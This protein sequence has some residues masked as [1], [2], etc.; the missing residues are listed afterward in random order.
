MAHRIRMPDDNVVKKVQ[1]LKVAGI[2]RRGSSRL[3]WVDSM[4]SVFGII[5]EKTWRTKVN[6]SRSQNTQT[7][8][9]RCLL[10]IIKL[11]EKPSGRGVAFRFST[12]QVQRSINGLGKINL[13][14]H[15]LNGSIDEYQACLGGLNIGG[16]APWSPPGRNI[17]SCISAPKVTNT[18][19]S[20]E[21]LDP[22]GLLRHCV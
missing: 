12:P 21:G 14:F 16:F 18:E 17:C 10:L 4:E 8:P 5:N 3:R 6:H 11:Y 13:A 2:R 7:H 20:R 1:Q 22:R 19:I 15:P 9:L